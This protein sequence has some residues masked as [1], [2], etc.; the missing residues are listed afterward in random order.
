[1]LADHAD[2]NREHLSDLENGKYDPTLGLLER[3]AFALELRL[4]DFF[5]QR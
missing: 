5:N 1:M 4:S 3:V 2:M